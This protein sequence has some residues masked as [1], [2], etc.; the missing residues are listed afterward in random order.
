MSKSDFSYTKHIHDDKRLIIA[1]ISGDIYADMTA[2]MGYNLRLEAKEREYRLILDFRDT[3]IFVSVLEVHTWFE[4]YYE[5]NGKDIEIR[6]IP[7]VLLYSDKDEEIFKFLE[8]SWSNKG[9]L[10][11]C[12]NSEEEAL[13]WFNTL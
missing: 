8:N 7:T 6:F 4:T 5:D 13:N 12:M 3:N 11:K 9:I 1:R 2:S 10:T